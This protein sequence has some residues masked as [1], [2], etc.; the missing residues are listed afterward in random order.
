MQIGGKVGMVVVLAIEIDALAVVRER[1]HQ[2]VK[3]QDIEVAEG[4]EAD[5]TGFRIA[6]EETVVAEVAFR[7]SM[8]MTDAFGA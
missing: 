4:G 1:M 5:E 8:R 7:A 6:L 3:T 2:S